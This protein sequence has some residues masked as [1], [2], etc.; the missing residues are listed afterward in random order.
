MPRVEPLTS[1]KNTQKTP[2][3]PKILAEMPG[4]P[5]KS[6]QTSQ[7]N[8]NYYLAN[9]DK[10]INSAKAKYRSLTEAGRCLRRWR[11]D[12]KP[13]FPKPGSKSALVARKMALAKAYCAFSDTDEVIRIYMACAEV[14]RPINSGV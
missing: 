4:K 11:Q 8:L 14:C 3:T 9:R 10:V 2:K 1:P 7:K 12:A 6:D 13:S 5:K